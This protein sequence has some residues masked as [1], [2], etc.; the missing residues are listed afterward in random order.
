MCNENTGNGITATAYTTV[1]LSI[2]FW[3]TFIREGNAG[4]Q[5]EDNGNKAVTVFSAQLPCPMLL[6]KLAQLSSPS[7]CQSQLWDAGVWHSM[8]LPE[9][10]PC[11]ADIDQGAMKRKI[12]RLEEKA[13]DKGFSWPLSASEEQWRPTPAVA[14]VV[15]AS[16]RFQSQ[17]QGLPSEIPPASSLSLAVQTKHHS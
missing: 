16:S 4:S 8:F 5:R 11:D 6:L 9:S 3:P 7:P 1:V 10:G 12:R 14:V 17:L 2:Y 15:R 13:C